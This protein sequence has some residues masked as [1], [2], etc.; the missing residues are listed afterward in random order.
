[1]YLGKFL[2]V[3]TRDKDQGP[4]SDNIK[5]KKYSLMVTVAGNAANLVGKNK[6]KKTLWNIG[7]DLKR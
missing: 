7:L 3:F 1:M 4:S 2:L 6:Q 5:P